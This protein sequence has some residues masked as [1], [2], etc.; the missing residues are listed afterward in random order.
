MNRSFLRWCSSTLATLCCATAFAAAPPVNYS[1]L[2]GK[3]DEPGW[4]LNLAQ[5]DTALFGTFFVY[6]TGGDAVWYSSTF[7]YQSTGAGGVRTYQGD[8]Y[9]TQGT[10]QGSTY[11]PTLLKYRQVGI[12]TLEFDGDAN[13]LLRYT[14]DGVVVTKLI[15]RQTF[16]TISPVGDYLGSTADITY[17]C[18]TSSNNGIITTDTGALRITLV[19]DFATIHAPTCF[20]EGKYKQQ[21]SVATLDG[22]Y[23]CTN[24]AT[25]GVTFTGLSIQE[26]GLVG[27]YTGTN[28]S[29]NF[30]GTIGGARTVK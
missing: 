13:A 10:P 16:G 17:G 12:A 2:W 30:R 29:C 26:G 21:G 15:A 7:V 5:Q 27:T 22:R 11:D 3:A 1:D 24:N 18:K 25:G 14:V 8:L 19:G 4:G 23:E 28:G 9:L 6:G 20:Y